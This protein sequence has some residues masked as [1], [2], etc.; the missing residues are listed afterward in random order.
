[1]I[2]WR[3]ECQTANGRE[4]LLRRHAKRSLGRAGRQVER[5]NRGERG[6]GAQRPRLQERR[7]GRRM[8]RRPRSAAR[9]RSRRPVA[10]AKPRIEDEDEIEIEDEIERRTGTG[11]LGRVDG[12][13]AEADLLQTNV[14]ASVGCLAGAP[15]ARIGLPPQAPEPGVSRRSRDGACSR[16]NE[17]PR[18]VPPGSTSLGMTAVG[19]RL[20]RMSPMC[21]AHPVIPTAAR[22]WPRLLCH[23]ERN[24]PHGGRSRGISPGRLRRASACRH[25]LLS[26]ESAGA[27]ATALAPVPTRSL[28]SCRQAP[29]R[30]G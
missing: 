29:L 24:P 7:D 20:L 23:P 28:G 12:L 26:Q 30:S 13:W 8:G 15:A 19:A 22:L 5:R 6:R 10:A 18:L 25:R 9:S 2:G 17:I 3:W 21:S 16:S 14:P 1:M 27:P 11:R 4:A